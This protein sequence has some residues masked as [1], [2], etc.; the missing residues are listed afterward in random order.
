MFAIRLLRRKRIALRTVAVS[1]DQ[2]ILGIVSRERLFL[3]AILQNNSE[4]P[5]L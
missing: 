1:T 3:V 4:T 5:L 2:E